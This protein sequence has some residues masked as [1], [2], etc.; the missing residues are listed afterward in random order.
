MQAKIN[1][2]GLKERIIIHRLLGASIA[3]MAVFCLGFVLVPYLAA[4]ASATTNLNA[5]VLWSGINLTLDP[6]YG[7]G[8][9]GDAGHGDVNFGTITPTSNSGNNKGTM[10]VAKRTIGITSSGRYYAVYISMYN[11]ASSTAVNDLVLDGSSSV[12]IPAISGTSSP[13]TFASP[14]VFSS[15]AWGYAV[16][17][18]P[19]TNGF[20]NTLAYSAYPVSSA[21]GNVT[22]DLTATNSNVYNTTKWAAVPIVN[23]TAAAQ[24]IWKYETEDTKG[25][26]IYTN[27]SGI[28]ITGDTEHNHFDIYY[29]TMVDT[30]TIAGEYSNQIVYTAMASARSL[31]NVSTNVKR[32]KAF[33]GVGDTV[34]L[35]FDLAASAASLTEDNLTVAIVKHNVASLVDAN[36]LSSN[37]SFDVNDYAECESIS[38]VVF[39]ENGASLDCE[40]P[41][42][43]DGIL[44]KGDS[45][46]EYDFWI[47]V[48][49]YGYNYLSRYKDGGNNPVASFSYVGLQS[50]MDA[51][52][53]DPV[54]TEMQEVTGTICEQTNRWNNQTGSNARIYDYAGSIP[55]AAAG[56]DV[57]GV[58]SFLLTDNRDNK[59]YKVRRMADGKCWMVQNLAL[60]L[61]DFVGTQ[62]LTR[63]NTD[64]T[65]KTYWDPGESMYNRAH[66]IDSTVTTVQTSYFPVVS[67]DRL[68]A[69]QSYQFQDESTTGLVWGSYYYDDAETGEKTLGGSVLNNYYAVMPRSYMTSAVGGFYN[70]YAATA[71]SVGYATRSA[72]DSIC[73]AGWT[74]PSREYSDAFSSTYSLYR[75]AADVYEAMPVSFQR[76]GRYSY[77][78]GIVGELSNLFYW[79]STTSGSPQNS[80]F[81]YTTNGEFG[82]TGAYHRLFGD[83]V[84]CVLKD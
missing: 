25:F 40:L 45:K 44:G 23:D 29:A 19:V 18:S 37:V 70:W 56:V 3:G 81:I 38:N 74:L 17:G 79:T 4:E 67:L 12:V 11:P 2:R 20:D 60:D 47:K 49:N 55:L 59:T 7:R 62:D 83:N 75:S 35:D 32:N 65:T 43:I 26:G 80:W 64:L 82:N 1:L 9:M 5:S 42:S 30:D 66:D 63:E 36:T 61:A 13:A 58:S 33:G 6:D 77:A 68:G 46:G 51:A 53:N 21:A 15:S 72:S 39:T 69:V 84:R 8:E 16:P 24:M 78:T 31:D 22:N 52:G 48:N 54:V 10:R 27:N 14:V 73:P 71:E 41:E 50:T 34:H 57:N 28:E 76:N